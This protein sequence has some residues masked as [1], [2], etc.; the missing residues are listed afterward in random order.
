MPAHELQEQLD[1]LRKQV[2]QDSPLSEEQRNNL[3][4]L[5]R[6]I[7]LQLQREASAPDTN[8]VDGVNL[9]ADRFEIEHP[10]VAG[11]LR[12]ILLSLSS[13]GI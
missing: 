13:M 2:E 4:D 1:T 8:L 3:Q 9:A 11:T 10:T 7:E 6:Q 5:S 12:S